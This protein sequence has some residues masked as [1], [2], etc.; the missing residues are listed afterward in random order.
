MHKTKIDWAEYSW[1]PVTGC[2]GPYGTEQAP[3]RCSYCYAFKL[4]KRLKGRFGYPEDDPFRPVLH[5]DRLDEPKRKRK[6]ARIFVCSMG[7]LL[8]PWIP[9]AWIE[10]VIDAMF[11]APQHTYVLLTKQPRSISRLH[12]ALVSNL[13]F[14]LGVSVESVDVIR[15]GRFMTFCI[16][17]N[18]L[19]P[20]FGPNIR[21]V[22]SF[23]PLLGPVPIA[24]PPILD[25]VIIGAQTNP[26]RLPKRKWVQA[27]IEAARAAG[28]PI[29]LKDNLEWP[30]EIKEFPR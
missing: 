30:E 25:W 1:N 13:K 2:Y 29:F 10:A 27:L 3:R 16:E 28:I 7:E 26:K 18:K 12:R 8:G 22:A 15:L 21:L 17:A 11:V 20:D 4:A 23:E 5:V 19:R 14:W 24:L 9:Q 6:P